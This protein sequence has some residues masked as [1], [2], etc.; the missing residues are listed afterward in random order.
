MD[1]KT[2]LNIIET[3][4]L[5]LCQFSGDDSEFILELLNTPGWIQFIGDKG[6]RTLDDAKNYIVNGP[7]KSYERFGFGLY[8]TKLKNE[9]TPIG[10]CG[11][12]KRDNL[13]DV[14]IG[15]SFLPE[16]TGKGY[17]LES[18][19]ATLSYGKISLGL[20]RIVAITNQDNYKSIKLLDKLGFQF[21]K[22]LTLTDVKDELMLFAI[23]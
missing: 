3:D 22:K 11:L 2:R 9:D 21:E 1:L 20:K 19:S 5:I 6:I 13:D 7:M 8:L 17:A 23:E 18:A 14:D 4:R 15:F 12:I 10:M 16:Y